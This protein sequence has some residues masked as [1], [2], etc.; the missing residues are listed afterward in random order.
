MLNFKGARAERSGDGERVIPTRSGQTGLINLPGYV[1][2]IIAIDCI[3]E[4]P[5]QNTSA[6]PFA[7]RSPPAAPCRPG[8]TERTSR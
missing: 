4:Y 1:I 8:K 2:H 5:P 6:G 7:S 3:F